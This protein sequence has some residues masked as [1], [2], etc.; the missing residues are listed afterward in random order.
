VYNKYKAA[1]KYVLKPQ[2]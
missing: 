1:K 2:V